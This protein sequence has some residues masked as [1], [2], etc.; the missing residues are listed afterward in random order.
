[1]RDIL[2][3]DLKRF[4]VANED[5]WNQIG[6]ACVDDDLSGRAVESVAGNIRTMIQDFEYT[7]GYFKA[8]YEERARMVDALSSRVP[9]SVVG[10]RIKDYVLFHKEAEEEADKQQF[11]K[12]VEQMVHQLN[13]GREA[14]ARAALAAPDR[15][16]DSAG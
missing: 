14:A 6:Q 13:A 11:E 15:V 3:G 1:M 7:E 8:S 16:D 2:L 4:V 12:D 9:A 10:E 5:E